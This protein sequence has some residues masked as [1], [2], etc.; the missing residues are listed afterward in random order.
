VPE[1]KVMFRQNPNIRIRN[2]KQIPIS[3]HKTI[4]TNT[5]EIRCFCNLDICILVIVSDFVLRISDF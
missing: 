2:S 4:Q 1:R 5:L 3:N